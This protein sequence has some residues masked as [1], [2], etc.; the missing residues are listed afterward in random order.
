MDRPEDHIIPG[1]GGDERDEAGNTGVDTSGAPIDQAPDLS[2]APSPT[3]AD[4]QEHAQEPQPT[5]P[6]AQADAHQWPRPDPS[7][8]HDD[9]TDTSQFAAAASTTGAAAGQ[10]AYDWPAPQ[11]PSATITE[12]TQPL[13]G[14]HPDDQ[15][16]A[17]LPPISTS[18][19]TP[20]RK[21]GGARTVGLLLGAGGAG[22]GCRH[23][24]WGSRLSARWLQ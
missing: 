11:G 17:G 4:S 9:D 8:V 15:P 19:D 14:L 16:P 6:V 1:L 2:T 21:S 23:R 18:T 13:F 24:W 10:S 12:P 22:P 3:P 20:T 5:P 7:S